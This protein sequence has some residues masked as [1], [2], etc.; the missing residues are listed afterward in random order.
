MRKISGDALKKND[1]N[2][3][4]NNLNWT[5]GIE[6]VTDFVVRVSG[7]DTFFCTSSFHK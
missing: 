2:Q 7:T 5:G 6:C 1:G 3:E 4:I